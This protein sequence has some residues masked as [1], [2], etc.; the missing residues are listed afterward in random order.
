MG[1]PGPSSEYYASFA[2]SFAGPI[3]PRSP[4]GSPLLSPT[5]TSA[6]TLQTFSENSLYTI[7]NL[8]KS[9]SDAEIRDRYRSLASTYHPDRQRDEPSRRSAHGRFT[10]IQ[11]VYEIL[12][13]PTKRTIYDLLGEEG[14][15]TSWEVGPRNQ[16][17]EELRRHYQRQAYDKRQL[18]AEA[19]VK[20][21]GDMNVVLDARPVFLSESSFKHPDRYS[22]DLFSRFG[23]IRTGRVSMNHSFQT[24]L[25][26]NTQLVLQG[27]MITRNGQG[28][29]NVVGTIRHQFSPKLWMEASSTFLNPYLVSAKGTYA[30]DEDT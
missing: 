21:K 16:S 6:E 25:A 11:R 23:R 19:L 28:G 12:T 1:D 15:K 17:P 30:Y 7:F 20:P 9:A 4:P 29:A 24:P 13:D 2:A 26:E 3:R 27:Q 18:E 8:P 14:L 22:H 10:E 5:L